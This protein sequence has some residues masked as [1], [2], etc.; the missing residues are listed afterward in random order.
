MFSILAFACRRVSHLS[1]LRPVNEIRNR[2]K[3]VILY[4]ST[5]QRTHTPRHC[6]CKPFCYF[7]V[8]AVVDA[9]SS[10]VLDLD[11]IRA[12]TED[13]ILTKGAYSLL[14]GCVFVFWDADCCCC[15]SSSTISRASSSSSSS[16]SS[17]PRGGRGSGELYAAADEPSC[18]TP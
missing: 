5:K 15:C 4:K 3:Y 7:L 12:R 10:L 17:S 1:N 11:R 8:V 9:S 16:V 2:K 13:P 6:Q 14:V 18:A